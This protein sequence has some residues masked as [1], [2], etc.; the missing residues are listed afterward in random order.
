MLGA[1]PSQSLGQVLHHDRGNVCRFW[2]EGAQ[3][4]NGTKLDGISQP[5]LSAAVRSDLGSIL[6]VQEEVLG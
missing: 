6:V 4:A 1:Q 3:K 5:M 2:Q